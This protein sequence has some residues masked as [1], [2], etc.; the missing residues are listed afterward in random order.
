MQSGLNLSDVLVALHRFPS[1]HAPVFVGW[2][3]NGVGPLLPPAAT[4][5][6]VRRQRP[7]VGRRARGTWTATLDYV[8]KTSHLRAL[9]LSDSGQPIRVRTRR[10][11]RLAGPALCPLRCN[12]AEGLIRASTTRPARSALSQHAV[13]LPAWRFASHSICL[14]YTSPSPRDQRGSRMPSSA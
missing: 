2:H 3:L 7:H 14:L 12:P 6:T 8:Q 5:T 9:L 11:V 4:T 13:T 10:E 1:S